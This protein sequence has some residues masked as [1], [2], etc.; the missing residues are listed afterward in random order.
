[1]PLFAKKKD[2]KE[3]VQWNKNGD[4]PN[5]ECK[6]DQA[7]RYSEGKIIRYFRN[8]D[9]KFAGDVHCKQCGDTYHYH[10]WI[11]RGGSGQTVCPGDW[12]IPDDFDSYYALSNDKFTKSFVEVTEPK[13][14]SLKDQL[15]LPLKE[16][17]IPHQRTIPLEPAK[18]PN[19]PSIPLPQMIGE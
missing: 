4:H 11:D 14:E 17:Q 16:V 3:A 18:E 13:I 8:P 10:G 15:A 2:I 1:M 6:V 9:P 12:I 19:F 5:D 7:G